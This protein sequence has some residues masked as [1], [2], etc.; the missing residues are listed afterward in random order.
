MFFVF[1]SIDAGTA[2]ERRGSDATPKKQR[3]RT[4]WTMD[5]DQN[6]SRPPRV[7][8]AP[9]AIKYV[10]YTGGFQDA[11][12][13]RCFLAECDFDLFII[14][15]VC[16]TED[17]VEL[18]QFSL[19]FFSSFSNFFHRPGL[20]TNFRTRCSVLTALWYPIGNVSWDVVNPGEI[21]IQVCALQRR[22]GCM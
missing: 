1:P 17:M 20:P 2:V 12:R 11:L 7:E 15:E 3:G 16:L 6:L 10:E 8:P 18:V 4:G 19:N 22:T 9:A 5:V 14:L 21:V 13:G